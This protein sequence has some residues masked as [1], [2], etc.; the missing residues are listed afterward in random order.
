MLG[1]YGLRQLYNNK[2]H[3]VTSFE[4]VV[5]PLIRR[6]A[7]S[8]IGADLVAVQ[9]MNMPLPTGRVFFTNYDIEY[10]YNN[11]R[12]LGIKPMSNHWLVKNNE[13]F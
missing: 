8:T 5:F 3:L 9:P 1:N 12:I 13:H 6:V 4:Q 11:F 2:L 7:V 10:T